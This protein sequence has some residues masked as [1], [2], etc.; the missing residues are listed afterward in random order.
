MTPYLNSLLSFMCYLDVHTHRL[1]T[2]PQ[3]VSIV[4]TFMQS[5]EEELQPTPYRSF[6]I[7]P[8]RIAEDGEAQWKR[9]Q[10]MAKQPACV[11]IGEA[12]LDRL[13]PCPMQRQRSLFE[14]QAGLAEEL[15]KPLIIHC[16]RAWEELIACRKAIRPKQPWVIH[17]FRGKATLA[18]QL[19]R[20]GFYLSLGYYF[21]PETARVAW[22]GRLFLETDEANV[23]I[24]VVYARVAE[25]LSI[26]LWALCDQIQRNSVILRLKNSTFAADYHSEL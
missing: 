21:Q 13:A 24:Q 3:V 7:H 26:D 17:G 4:S 8:C 16:V 18:D 23:S 11:A 2:D 12:G 15:G 19:L 6:G 9:L 20:Q 5:I 10:L 14:R 25:A 1:A 22:P